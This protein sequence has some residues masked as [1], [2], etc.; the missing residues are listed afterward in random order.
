MELLS[1]TCSM[2]LYKIFIDEQQQEALGTDLD[3]EITDTDLTSNNNSKNQRTKTTNTLPPTP[4]LSIKQ[5]AYRKRTNRI[6]VDGTIHKAQNKINNVCL[7]EE[8]NVLITLIKSDQSCSHCVKDSE[9]LCRR[10]RRRK[11]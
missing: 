6:K 5:I 3:I 8:I 10:R 4:N 1:V 7:Q 9:Q 11:R 2:I